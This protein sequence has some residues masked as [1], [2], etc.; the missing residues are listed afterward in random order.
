MASFLVMEF[1]AHWV[2]GFLQPILFPHLPKRWPSA[3]RFSFSLAF[4]SLLG[5]RL[6]AM[7][8]LNSPSSLC[9]LSLHAAPSTG[10]ALPISIF[11]T[12]LTWVLFPKISLVYWFYH[13]LKCVQVSQVLQA[14]H[15]HRV[16]ESDKSSDNSTLSSK[17]NWSL[18]DLRLL[19]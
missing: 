11:F 10:N 1:Y 9:P 14:K 19:T 17:E 18:N 2:L 13:L 7:S 8:P 12:R 5:T 16:T 6:G 15:F 4:L 3:L